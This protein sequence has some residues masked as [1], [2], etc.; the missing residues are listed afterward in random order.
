MEMRWGEAFKINSK[1][2]IRNIYTNYKKEIMRK[3]CVV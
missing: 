2:Y 3:S 1:K